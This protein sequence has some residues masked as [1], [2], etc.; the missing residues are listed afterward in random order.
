M[1]T[2][3]WSGRRSRSARD[4]A[5]GGVAASS[6][7]P[8]APAASATSGMVTTAYGAPALAA[9]ADHVG[10]AKGGDP[11][12]P[13]VVVVPTDRIGVGARRGLARAGIGARS[14]V[15]GISVMTLR[16]LAESLATP[17]LT[18]AGR[19][20]AT[21]AV[22]VAAFA[23][24]LAEAPGVFGEVA[25]HPET[26]RALA[27]AHA[28]L[29]VA[30]PEVR[31]RIASTSP[32]ATDVMR[33]HEAAVARLRA[34]H[35]DEVDL[36]DTAT[37]LLGSG[38]VECPPVVLFL[39]DRLD[40]AQQRFVRA[41]A[42]RTGVTAIVG[43]SGAAEGDA[44]VLREWAGLLGEPGGTVEVDCPVADAVVAA[45]DPDDEVRAVVRDIVARLADGTP[46]HRICVLYGARQPYA[47]LLA[48]HLAHAGVAFNGRGVRPT[49]ERILGRALRR[50]LALPGND[51]RRDEVMALLTDAP[52]R[53]NAKRAP[54]TGWERLSRQAGVI[55]GR[56]WAA[57]LAEHA[58]RR[59]AAARAARD[60]PDANGWAGE[61]D[62]R[63]A[64]DAEQLA[65][66][67][68]DLMSRLDTLAGAATW[69]AAQEVLC[70]LWQ[71]VLGADDVGHLPDE[72]RRAAD[73]ID[74]IIRSLPTLDRVGTPFSIDALRDLVEFEL[75]ADLDRVG[76]V[77][78]GVHVGPVSQGVGLDLDAV[79][80]VGMAEGLF[81]PRPADDPL[82][83]DAA[84][85]LTG[86]VLPTMRQRIDD[87]HRHFLAALAAAPAGSASQPRRV[88][89]FP[90]GDLRRGGVRV[91]SRWLLPT[92]AR[93]RGRDVVATE[94]EPAP[95]ETVAGLRVLPSYAGAVTSAATPGTDQEWRQRACAAGLRT[96]DP[97]SRRAREMRQARRTGAFTRFDG[98]VGAHHLLD[99]QTGAVLSPTSLETWFQCPH[100]Y[101]VKQVLGVR[102]VE[103]PEEI[104]QIS[105]MDRGTL[106]HRVLDRFVRQALDAGTQPRGGAPWS[107]ADQ[108]RLE[109]IIDEEFAE[110]ER[111][112]R[113]GLAG[114][115]EAIARGVREDLMRF[116]ERDHD[117]RRPG[118]LAPSA[119]ELA[120][121]RDGA[122][123]VEIPLGDGRTVRIRGSIDRL[124][125]GPRGLVVLDYKTGKA[126]KYGKLAAD[127]PTDHGRFLQLP[128]YATAARQRLGRPDAPTEVAYWFITRAERY[129]PLG[130]RVSDETEH[131]VRAVLRVAVDGIGAGLFPPRPKE[132]SKGY[133][134]P[135]CDPDGLGERV[136]VERFE[137]WLAAPELQPYA[138]VIVGQTGVVGS[139][140]EE[141]TA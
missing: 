84:R 90:R 96:D 137:R 31:S 134:C 99:R 50:V 2:F 26:A 87:Q 141:V 43:V 118:Q 110:E 72:E 18:A 29:G 12:A 37:E 33:L 139:A 20:P 135:Y 35:Y 91:P 41:L 136:P 19:M 131:A 52:V 129:K 24:L 55:R 7:H 17:P 77:G 68:R 104:V 9:L 120:F 86:G 81:P 132:H 133:T 88:L 102:E 56:D 64:D 140:G 101:L 115:W 73:S 94:W 34:S 95:D 40:P 97:V 39:P 75:D 76:R 126:G 116:P 119:C 48:E 89:T 74:R 32:V 117:R 10:R 85:A 71:Q 54:A 62:D 100:Q 112:G 63:A 11:L 69:T 27:R 44:P 57:R 93:L 21:R 36:L 16:R 122:P 61:R 124:D 49:G 4:A 92:L 123:A 103:D 53:W 28:E 5:G 46:G 106:M 114:L 128:L 14:G 22:A 80:V 1:G 47:R 66:F 42:G 15:A 113:V 82:I 79:Y 13:V 83:P 121:G 59:R 30:S 98:L 108:E 3:P 58:A 127:N 45:T 105:A 51:F 60:L 78:V 107:P 25:G 125:E 130:Y 70:A 109:R 138:G 65:A 8:G 38:T 67:V 23:G 6:A 111:S